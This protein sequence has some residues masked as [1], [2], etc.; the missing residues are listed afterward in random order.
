MSKTIFHGIL[1]FV[2]ALVIG[3]SATAGTL[4]LGAATY[5]GENVTIPVI[6]EGDIS[7]GASTIA[8]SLQYDDQVLEPVTS[9]A[10]AAASAADKLVQSN[11]PSPGQYKVIM[12][13]MNQSTM[14]SGEVATI[15]MRVKDAQ[16]TQA[17]LSIT[18]TSF[19]SPAGTEIPSQG[20]TQTLKFSKEENSGDDNSQ[21]NQ[22]NKPPDNRNN[23]D[24]RGDKPTSESDSSSDSSNTPAAGGPPAG[25]PAA[26]DKSS[27]T[28][29]APGGPVTSVP[30]PM[31]K[32][33]TSPNE[34]IVASLNKAGSTREGIVTPGT[35]ALA[36]EQ[37]N[38]PDGQSPSIPG[39]ATPSTTEGTA[40]PEG[41]GSETVKTASV[42]SVT[43][44][45]G[46][47]PGAT[48]AVPAADAPGIAAT[49]T[50]GVQNNNLK[51]V[52]MGA[53]VVVLGALFFVRKKLVS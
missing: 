23:E 13:G 4:R 29:N 15:T 19:A 20:S 52:I 18:N 40:A 7:G 25:T 46:T 38:K 3:L 26:T 1:M 16:A 47:I 44:T 42:A 35:A 37:S 24:N 14:T 11:V 2:S 39:A 32:A 34:R 36:A 5:E 43:A 31:A 6:L 28:Y 33:G 41:A 8:F 51:F 12:M 49:A 22:E 48:A 30:T 17:D 10:G 53:I 9:A 50:G 27:P 21:N 45:G